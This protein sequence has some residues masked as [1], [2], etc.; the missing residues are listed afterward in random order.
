MFS[1]FLQ[2]IKACDPAELQLKS[3]GT[4]C[5]QIPDRVP[6]FPAAPSPKCTCASCVCMSVC[7]CASARAC[8]HVHVPVKE[9][10][11]NY[12]ICLTSLRTFK[13]SVLKAANL[14][15][16]EFI[17]YADSNELGDQWT[18]RV[19]P[20]CKMEAS[21]VAAQVASSP[22][23]VGRQEMSSEVSAGAFYIRSLCCCSD[24]YQTW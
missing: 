1:S 16:S 18:A 23:L 19:I 24:Q 4:R 11:L 21:P 7:V 15:S 12:S 3:V 10:V 13:A 6:R 20:H 8:V 14:W 17:L 22:V 9:D 5:F 2:W